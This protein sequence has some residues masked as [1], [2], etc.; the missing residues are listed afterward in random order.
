VIS[1]RRW[2][3]VAALVVMCAVYLLVFRLEALAPLGPLR[4]LAATLLASGPFALAIWASQRDGAPGLPLVLAGTALLHLCVPLA[5]LSGTDDAFRYLWDGR[6]LDHG[7]NPYAHAPQ[8]AELAALREPNFHPHIYRPD[9]RTVYPPLAE[10]WFWVAYRLSSTSLVGLKIVLL[11]HQLAAAWILVRLTA[12]RG[13][14]LSLIYAW[15]PLAVVQLMAGAHLDGLMIP[16][17]LLAL[18]LSD[19]WPLWSGAA[20]GGAAMVRPTAALCVPALLARRPL[21]QAGAAGLGV[22]AVVSGLLLPFLGARAGLYESLL[23]YARHWRFNG[24]LFRAVEHVVE[25]KLGARVATYSAIGAVSLG[26]AWLTLSLPARFLI[27][28]GAYLAL[29]P[30]VYPW[31]VLPAAAVGALY[32]GPLVIA[33][34]A[35]VGISDL[36]YVEKLR[37][38]EWQV[39]TLALL[40]EYGMIYVLLVWEVVRRRLAARRESN[41]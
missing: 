23:V 27:A 35:L 14:G 5:L 22:A 15:S 40:L 9:M 24:S 33:L 31:Y 26:G 25:D 4:N 20:L 7:I 36:V 3:V 38:G 16:W 37:T 18:C 6:V 11:A 30:T 8:S 1:G 39:P 19:R 17:L 10:L 12:E 2:V 13:Q 29:A 21:K 41:M 32:G 28:V 34:P